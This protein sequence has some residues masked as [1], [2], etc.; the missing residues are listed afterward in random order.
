MGDFW[1]KNVHSLVLASLGKNKE[2]KSSGLTYATKVNIWR[3]ATIFH[4]IRMSEFSLLKGVTVVILVTFR[5]IGLSF[6][7]YNI[8]KNYTWYIDTWTYI[9][10]ICQ[11]GFFSSPVSQLNTH[12]QKYRKMDVGYTPISIKILDRM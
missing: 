4:F 8:S 3:F 1:D 10:K 11:S 9:Y 7:V 12:M 2:N 6:S 5:K